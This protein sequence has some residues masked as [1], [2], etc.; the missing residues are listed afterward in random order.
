MLFEF[1]NLFLSGN[2]F[3]RVFHLS[4]NLKF[5]YFLLLK[6]PTDPAH[7][8]NRPSLTV[9]P[10][11][12]T[13]DSHNASRFLRMRDVP[14]RKHVHLPLTNVRSHSCLDSTT[15]TSEREASPRAAT[16][17]CR[18]ICTLTARP[19]KWAWKA[20]TWPGDSSEGWRRS[21]DLAQ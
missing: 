12:G 17:P 3:P 18:Q 14:D 11:S 19:A 4:E 6:R 7:R 15:E 1:S 2:E 13:T 21:S 9:C 8:L 16:S 5:F 10:H 20:T